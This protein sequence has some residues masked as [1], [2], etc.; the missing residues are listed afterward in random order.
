LRSDQIDSP[1]SDGVG[2]PGNEGIRQA[3]AEGTKRQLDKVNLTAELTKEAIRRHVVADAKGDIRKLFDEKGN[4]R[5]ITELDDAEAM[6]IGGFEVVI[7]NAA[8]GDGHTGTVLKI[9]LRDQ[10][11][12]V[13]MAAKHFALLTDAVKVDFE[14]ALMDRLARGRMRVVEMKKKL[15]QAG[16]PERGSPS[17]FG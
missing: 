17:G 8:A 10:S 11:S 15:L 6:L 3:I 14:Q 7:K 12:Y 13:E 16:Q 9:R 1:G 2:G 5:P 4:V